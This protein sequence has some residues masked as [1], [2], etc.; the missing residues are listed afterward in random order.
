MHPWDHH[1][2]SRVG[3]TRTPSEASERPKYCDNFLLYSFYVAMVLA[4]F[5]S[6]PM[7]GS[8]ALRLVLSLPLLLLLLL[9]LQREKQNAVEG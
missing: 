9:L 1:D 5:P 3:Q 2:T 8:G 6:I 4:I 7:N